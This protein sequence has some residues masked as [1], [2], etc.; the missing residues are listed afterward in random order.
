MLARVATS[1]QNIFKIPELR[2][3]I[4]FTMAILAVY[5]FAAH[6]PT[7]GI[8][9]NELSAFL[10]ERGG[11]IM[12]FLDIFSGGALSRLTIVALGIMPY[13]SASIIMQLMTVVIP[14]LAQLSKEG[15]A[16]RR[17]ITQYTRYLTICIG[18]VQ[19][20]GIAV[21]LEGMNDGAF[22]MNPGWS[23]R[24]VVVVTLV[25]GTALLMWLGEQVTERG[26]GNGISLIIFSGIVAGM[27]AAIVN[28]YQL[29]ESGQL[30]PVLILAILAMMCVVIGAI[31]FLESGR[32]KL[33]V[34]Y[35]RRVV[36]NRVYGGQNTHIPLKVNTAGVIPP[37]FASS[38]IAFP[39]TIAGFFAIPWV[40]GL[41]TSLSPGQVPYTILYV[42]LIIFFAF[43]YTAVVLNPVDIADNM[44]KSG[45]FIPGIRPGKR[46]SD[47]IYY[48]LTRITF[49]G[50]LYLAAIC[51]I[52]ELLIYNL[53]LPFYFGG[54][55]LLIVVSVGLDTSQQIETHMIQR[56]YEGFLKQGKVRGRHD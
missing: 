21:G 51:V 13:I 42:G 47:Y 46:T 34:Q 23:F 50:A 12:G 52:P 24:F 4:F 9:G 49:A 7:P 45:G 10:L 15:E 19:A 2:S 3:R 17:V 55:S 6:V 29:Y 18:L 53:G 11:A 37:I 27:P 5:R 40:Q 26:I 14:T 43:F 31:V 39:A 16:G 33:A 35:A 28:T 1:I 44:K 20:S 25:G 36:G 8:N 56:N 32:R 54:T 30:N 38:M 48:V 22:V 41:A